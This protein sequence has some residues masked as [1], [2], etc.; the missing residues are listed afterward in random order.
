MAVINKDPNSNVPSIYHLPD[1]VFDFNIPAGTSA[2][3]NKFLQ[4]HTLKKPT[5]I[6]VWP[7]TACVKFSVFLHGYMSGDFIGE[8]DLGQQMGT[9]PGGL[10]VNPANLQLSGIIG[11]AYSLISNEEEEKNILYP[12]IKIDV[13]NKDGA[14]DLFIFGF[15]IGAVP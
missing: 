14:N 7:G 5:L 15:L 13:D 12:W 8:F 9:L 3:S 6:L 2:Q 11:G 10:D 1:D 4:V